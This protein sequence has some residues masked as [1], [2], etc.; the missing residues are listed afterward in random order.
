MIALQRDYKMCSNNL[1]RLTMV[2]LRILAE[3]DGVIP[4]FS[5]LDGIIMVQLLSPLRS[6][7]YTC[8]QFKFQK[9]ENQIKRKFKNLPSPSKKQITQQLKSYFNN[10]VETMR[11]GDVPKR[12]HRTSYHA[13]QLLD[14]MTG[15]AHFCTKA[16]LS[17]V[18]SLQ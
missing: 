1:S 13:Y 12:L 4:Y 14:H 7:Q 3:Y 18:Y 9:I 2:K 6:D 16:I 8:L 11:W 15:R 17:K 5:L 10:T